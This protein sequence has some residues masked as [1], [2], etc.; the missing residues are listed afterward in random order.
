MKAIDV[1]QDVGTSTAA[2]TAALPSAPPI[3]SPP[4]DDGQP[5]PESS[6][7]SDEYNKTPPKRTG[8]VCVCSSSLSHDS[9]D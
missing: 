3:V 1:P 5:N 4:T 7:G 8:K 2:S 6:Y 9:S